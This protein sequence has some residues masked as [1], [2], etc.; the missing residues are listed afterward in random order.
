[1]LMIHNPAALQVFRKMFLCAYGLSEPVLPLGRIIYWE[2]QMER[3][4]QRFGRAP[5]G[6][7]QWKVL[8]AGGYFFNFS[9][10]VPPASALHPALSA[11]AHAGVERVLVPA[12]I[13][14]PDAAAIAVGFHGVP[15]FTE[16]WVEFGERSVDEHLRAQL[17]GR[18]YRDLLRVTRKAHDAYDWQLYDGAALRSAPEVCARIADLHALNLQQH[19]L[20]LNFF[21]VP[22][23]DTM[24]SSMLAPSVRAIVR[25][26]RRTGQP[27]Q[28]ILTWVDA[29]GGDVYVLAHGID[30]DRVPRDQNLYRA[31]FV[32]L[33]RRGQDEGA[34]RVFLGRGSPAEKRRIGA[35]RFRLLYHW[36]HGPDPDGDL[37]TL[38]D[39]TV[40]LEREQTSRLCSAR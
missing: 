35:N 36:M 11:A 39:L 21:T 25:H 12:V 22:V 1:M 13:D 10:P 34:G 18:R 24:L 15:C 5:T 37:A 6:P 32:E 3:L 2:S 19:G 31:M 16:A 23:L 40:Q 7:G 14:A 30:H 9:S 38:T 8:L 27:V 26:D 33:M 4:R 29:M 17:G 20:C 28:M